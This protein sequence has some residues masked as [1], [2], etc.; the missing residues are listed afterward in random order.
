MNAKISFSVVGSITQTLKILNGESAESIAEKLNTGEYV[1]SV[2]GYR[3]IIPAEQI[4]IVESNKIAIIE[5]SD[6]EHTEYTD[7]EAE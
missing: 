1:T 3:Y 5:D 7:F 4:G 2:A 6:L